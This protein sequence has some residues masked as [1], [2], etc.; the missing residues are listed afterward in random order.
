MSYYVFDPLDRSE[1]VMGTHDAETFF[2]APRIHEAVEPA[3]VEPE[4]AKALGSL[5]LADTDN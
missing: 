1:A 5:M 4:T 2:H 3:Q